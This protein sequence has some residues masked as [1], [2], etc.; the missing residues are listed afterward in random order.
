M[1]TECEIFADFDVTSSMVQILEDIW[2]IWDRFLHFGH[3]GLFS[4]KL[5]GIVI[6][7]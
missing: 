2:E 5:M 6:A 4:F 3:K 7:L 1:E